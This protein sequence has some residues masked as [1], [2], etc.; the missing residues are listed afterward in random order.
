VE[1]VDAKR[2]GDF[3]RFMERY[4]R[5]YQIGSE[6]Y[7]ARLLRFVAHFEEAE[8][9][10]RKEGRLW[11][12][13]VNHLADRTEDELAALRGLRRGALHGSSRQQAA[14][15]GGAAA[16]LDETITLPE[17]H[18]W[19]HLVSL[20]E[21][22]VKDQGQCGSCWAHATI[23]MLENNAEI[24]GLDTQL[25]IQEI[26]SCVEN[27]MQCGGAGGCDGATV[28]L[29]MEYI[30]KNGL[31]TKNEWPYLAQNSTCRSKEKQPIA[32]MFSALSSVVRRRQ[33]ERPQKDIVKKDLLAPNGGL[34]AWR[35]LRPNDLFDVKAALVHTGPLAVAISSGRPWNLYQEGIMTDCVKDAIVDHAQVLIGYGSDPALFNTKYWS[36][37]NSWGSA[38]GEHGKIRIFRRADAE[39]ASYCGT[40]D[41]PEVGIGCEGGPKSVTVCG[42]CGVLYDAVAVYFNT[43]Y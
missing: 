42:E 4:S 11:T 15:G 23:T 6:E 19:E 43:R 20:G 21:Q 33:E 14:V 35:T 36:M 29:A 1:Q 27:P 16:L 31:S 5:E 30:M 10:N 8:A 3:H 34:G 38:W 41:K 22:R 12:A 13:A 17:S 39:E 18:S 25:S 26:V 9:H 2:V 28:E 7:N 40:D 32:S 37:M 24:Y